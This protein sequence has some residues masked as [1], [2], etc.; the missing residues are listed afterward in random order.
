MPSGTNEAKKLR[1][2]ARLTRLAFGGARRHN[3]EQITTLGM[4]LH[5]QQAPGTFGMFGITN[6]TVR[7][8][9]KTLD[10]LDEMQK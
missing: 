6:S 9:M 2:L 8:I 3:G 1:K 10:E 5:C 7:D 4:V